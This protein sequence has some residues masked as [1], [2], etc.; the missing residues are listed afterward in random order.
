MATITKIKAEQL[1]RPDTPEGLDPSGLR[2]DLQKWVTGI[3]DML[4]EENI[5][6]SGSRLNR[7]LFLNIRA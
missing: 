2:R 5:L 1:R 7:F 6:L 3:N 4:T